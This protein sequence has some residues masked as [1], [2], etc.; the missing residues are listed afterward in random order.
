MFVC[1]AKRGIVPLWVCFCPGAG[2]RIEPPNDLGSEAVTTSRSV[3]V[4]SEKAGV[5]SFG[6]HK[7]SLTIP[8]T[9]EH[10]IREKSKPSRYGFHGKDHGFLSLR[11]LDLNNVL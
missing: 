1:S 11:L 10:A 7:Q 2:G 9:F 5:K 4:W 8:L 3:G 6:Y